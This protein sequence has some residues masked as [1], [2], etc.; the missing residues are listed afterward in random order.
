[1][2]NKKI[3]KAFADIEKL[4]LKINPDG[5]FIKDIK[6]AQDLAEFERAIT[7]TNKI[8]E[9]QLAIPK[10]GALFSKIGPQAGSCDLPMGHEGLHQGLGPNGTVMCQWHWTIRTEEPNNKKIE[11]LYEYL[12]KY[13][14]HEEDADKIHNAYLIGGID[15]AVETFKW[16]NDDGNNYTDELRGA[17][18]IWEKKK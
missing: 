17:I 11:K 9:Q 14:Y 7:E 1:M 6:L 16:A 13:G 10:C 4:D 3:E 18:E 8:A 5:V 2:N 12:V 15:S